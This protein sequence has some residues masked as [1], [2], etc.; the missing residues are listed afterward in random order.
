[1]KQPPTCLDTAIELRHRLNLWPV[2]IKP[3]EKA[4]IGESW[5]STRPDERSIRETFK[6]FPKAGVGL[7]L[8][9]EAGIIDIE[10][11][12]PEGKA[13]LVKLM[14]GG[15]PLDPRVVIHPRPSSCLPLRCPACPLRQEHHQAARAARLGDQDRGERQA[16]AIELP[17]DDRD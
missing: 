12:A 5:G 17:A 15:D 7:V 16:T 13:S 1:M 11:D 14:G 8:G 6:R 9:P 3:G 4:P 2:A 10:C